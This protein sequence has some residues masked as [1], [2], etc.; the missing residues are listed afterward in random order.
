MSRVCGRAGEGFGTRVRAGGAENTSVWANIG[1]DA[2]KLRRR[3]AVHHNH[4]KARLAA[5]VVL[6]GKGFWD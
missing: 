3:R 1:V 5:H 2:Q 6:R 4:F